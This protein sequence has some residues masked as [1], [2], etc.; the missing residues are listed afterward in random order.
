MR[1]MVLFRV[2]CLCALATLALSAA[3]CGL[4]PEQRAALARYEKA[5]KEVE[6]RVDSYGEKVDAVIAKVKAK[7]IPLEEGQA[8][9]AELASNYKADKEKLAEVK[10][11][12]GKL[13][14]FEVPWYYYLGPIVTALLGLAGGRIPGLRTA[15]VLGA[16]VDGIEVAGVGKVKAA[17]RKAALD[18][19]VQ[20]ALSALVRERTG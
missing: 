1:W 4:S 3:G 18:A 6:A 14:E 13:K 2:A 10:S 15:K 19:G 16:V 12:V 11:A 7:E 20:P 8:L 9:I 17:V 5:V